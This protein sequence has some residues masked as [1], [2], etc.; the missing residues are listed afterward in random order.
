MSSTS[1]GGSECSLYIS[2]QIL[3]V[4]HINTFYSTWT[5]YYKARLLPRLGHLHFIL[6][7]YH[8]P[9]T[10]AGIILWVTKYPPPSAPQQLF[11]SFTESC[12]SSKIIRYNR[13]AVMSRRK[14]IDS[15]MIQKPFNVLKLPA[16]IR[17]QIWRYAVVLDHPITV[18]FHERESLAKRLPPSK[19]RSGRE[20][21]DHHRDDVKR[22]SSMLA[23]AFTSRQMYNEITPIY[24]S[25]NTFF[26]DIFYSFGSW[27]L[28][29]PAFTTAIGERN[30]RNI[31]IAS[32]E[33]EELMYY[34]SCLP[35]IKYL[36]LRRSFMADDILSKELKDY[37]KSHPDLAV[38]S[39]AIEWFKHKWWYGTYLKSENDPVPALSKCHEIVQ[40]KQNHH[41]SWTDLDQEY[42]H[43]LRLWNN[44]SNFCRSRL[45]ISATTTSNSSSQTEHL[46]LDTHQI[47]FHDFL[48]TW[49]WYGFPSF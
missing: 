47:V 48:M 7:T 17:S 25:E 30:T 11:K 2:L 21:E 3:T 13:F 40:L 14:K 1:C 41:R 49:R 5:S 32:F 37:M 43:P 9:W 46:H 8:L 36:R 23:V 45:K 12:Q 18:K 35:N 19:L 26:F 24:Y 28:S 39:N 15:S 29:L 20:M 42:H 44:T 38:T 4:S 22:T 31:T 33:Q 6:L 16:E 10:T 27:Q 34:F